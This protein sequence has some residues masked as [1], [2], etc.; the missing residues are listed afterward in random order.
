MAGA[1]GALLSGSG[2]SLDFIRRL[3][4]TDDEEDKRGEASEYRRTEI[5]M[6]KLKCKIAAKRKAGGKARKGV[7]IYAKG[8]G[9]EKTV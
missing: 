9:T 7:G 4:Y 3:C 8:Q 2:D 5:K 6:Q 1:A